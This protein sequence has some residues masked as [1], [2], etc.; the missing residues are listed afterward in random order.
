VNWD[1]M[2]VVGRIARPHGI[3]GQVVV[4]PETDFPQE[5]FHVGAE[6]FMKKAGAGGVE[7]VPERLVIATVR[8]HKQRP[9]IGFDGVDINQATT[10]AGSELRVPL[11]QLAELPPDMFYR[12]DLIGCAVDL[13]DGSSVGTVTGVEGTLGGSRLVVATSRGDVLVPLV[14]AICRSIDITAKR[15]VIDP[16]DG[17]IELNARRA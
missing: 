17:L 7:Q 6:L 16:P 2:A 3:R 12:H 14:A 15:I 9:I 5:R 8:F 1:E 11:D 13:V 10:L 4:N